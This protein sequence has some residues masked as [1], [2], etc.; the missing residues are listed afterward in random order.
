MNVRDV[1]RLA[2]DWK[3]SELEDADAALKFVNKPTEFIDPITK[4]HDL[5]GRSVSFSFIIRHSEGCAL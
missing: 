5:D 1:E 4:K 3:F 2:A